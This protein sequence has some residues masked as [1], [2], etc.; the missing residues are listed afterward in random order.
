MLYLLAA[1]ILAALEALALW[2]NIRWLEFIA[3]PTVMVFLFIYLWT[4][5]QLMGAALWFGIGILFSLTGDVFLLWLDR[6]FLAGLVAF[7]LA[8]LSYLTGFNTPPSPLNLWALL[9]ALIVGLGGVRVLRRILVALVQK[10]QARLR[11]PVTIYA[12]V[13]S[14]MLLSAMLK[15]TDMGWNAGASLLVAAGAFL[16]YLSDII[17]AWNQFV[18]PIPHGRILNISC[19]HLGQIL[20]I[21]G[22]AMQYSG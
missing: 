5:T 19:Y 4:S 7:L 13:I 10:G 17:F 8:H 11:I 22:A 14:L 12:M 2:K 9:L 3:K 18:A 6:F 20:L 21:V 1:L 15:L 16:F